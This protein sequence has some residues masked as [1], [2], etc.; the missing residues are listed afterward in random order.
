MVQG[1][2]MMQGNNVCPP[3]LLVVGEQVGLTDQ[4]GQGMNMGMQQQYG[5]GMG[6]AQGQGQGF[7]FDRRMRRARKHERRAARHA[8]RAER[9]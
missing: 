1:N 4:M 9:E 3:F 2:A 5:T 6:M 7:L 8:A